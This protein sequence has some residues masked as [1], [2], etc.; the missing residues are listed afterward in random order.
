MTS[1]ICL[2]ADGVRVYAV[3]R[4]HSNVKA[5]LGLQKY[6]T[7]EWPSSKTAPMAGTARLRLL[8]SSVGTVGANFLHE[9]ISTS[10]S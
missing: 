1:I 7:L 4:H 6:S 2:N 9:L 3:S 8:I 5:T 10:I